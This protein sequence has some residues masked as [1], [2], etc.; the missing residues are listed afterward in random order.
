MKNFLFIG[1]VFLPGFRDMRGKIDLTTLYN[2]I[3]HIP[4][5]VPTY[6]PTYGPYLWPLHHITK[7]K[8]R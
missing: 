8:R 7:D 6:V 4:T 1:R 3:K 5:Y 2:R